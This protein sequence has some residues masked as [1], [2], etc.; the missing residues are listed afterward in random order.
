MSNFDIALMI[1]AGTLVI[2]GMIKGLVR[3]LFGIAALVAAFALAARYHEP[4]SQRLA[5]LDLPSEPRRLLAYALIFLGVMIAGGILAYGG[6]KVIK[7]AMLGWA[8]RLG[9]AALGLVAALLAAALL[10]LPMVAYF[11]GTHAMLQHSI[12]APYVTVVCDLA[13]VIAPEGF[14]T[15][16]REGV[17][18]LRRHWR[19]EDEDGTVKV[20][21]QT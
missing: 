19:G 21:L 12:L 10:V 8:D 7:A 1:L 20:R 4:L 13:N 16:Y 14:S 6:R 17:E 5:T 3:I 9:G 15:R 18:G 11:P 2:V